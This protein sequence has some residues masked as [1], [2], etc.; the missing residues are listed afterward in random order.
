M[1]IISFNVNGIRAIMKKGLADSISQMK[2][3]IIGF[4]E[5]KANDDQVAEALKTVEGYH[6]YSS[7]AVRPGYSG[8]AILSKEK[9]LSV[10]YGLGKEIHDQEGRTI[11][12]EYKDF[13]VINSYIPNS[14]SELA[15]LPYRKEWDAD[16]LK[17]LQKLEAKKPVIFIGD[18]NVAH[19]PIDL[20]NPK[21]NYNKS[22]GYTQDEIDGMTT[23]KDHFVDTF[24][25]F[26]PETVKYSWWSARFNSRA[27]NVGWRIDYVLT[28][29]SLLPR[30]KDAF[31][32]NEIEG[33]DHCPVGIEIK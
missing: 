26:N 22:A 21:S 2:P 33:S 10:V 13:Y 1:R 30:I 24:R 20:A 28:S 15:R 27:K 4:Q 12:A 7:S 32:L 17:H 11:T 23:Y 5:T 3:D 18:M 8:T 6:L 19:Q 16:M 31:I 9:P 14:G 29:K 25:H